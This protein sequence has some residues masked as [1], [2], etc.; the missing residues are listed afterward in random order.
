MS[1]P[2]TGISRRIGLSFQCYCKWTK[3]SASGPSFIIYFYLCMQRPP[4]SQTDWILVHHCYRTT[5]VRNPPPPPGTLPAKYLSKRV[6]DRLHENC[7]WFRCATRL[8][9][10][11]AWK[12][13]DVERKIV[14]D[15]FLGGLERLR[16][17]GENRRKLLFSPIGAI[18]KPTAAAGTSTAKI[19][20]EAASPYVVSIVKMAL[21]I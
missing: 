11:A 8:A 1:C 4:S 20:M 17:W 15:L 13:M 16:R 5:M 19:A 14:G 12:L 2:S 10:V 6:S 18:V 7:V 9:R 3:I 21:T